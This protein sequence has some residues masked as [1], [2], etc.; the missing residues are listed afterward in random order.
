MG[1]F[2]RAG[3]SPLFWCDSTVRGSDNDIKMNELPLQVKM[4]KYP[5]SNLPNPPCASISLQAE[6]CDKVK[7]LSATARRVKD[8]V[9]VKFETRYFSCFLL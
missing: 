8:A 6:N 9:K 3:K 5:E 7:S 2:P 4:H 1:A